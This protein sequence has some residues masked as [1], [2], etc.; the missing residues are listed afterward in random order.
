MLRLKKFDELVVIIKTQINLSNGNNPRFWADLGNV[1]YKRGD[2]SQ[3]MSF[4]G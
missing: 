3:A 2:P 4:G 1:Y